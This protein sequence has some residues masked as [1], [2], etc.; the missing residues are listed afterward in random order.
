MRATDFEFR[1][2][3]WISTAIYL[4]GLSIYIFD[5]VNIVQ[6]LIDRTVGR[7]APNADLLA[8][9]IFGAGAFLLFLF[10]TSGATISFLRLTGIEEAKLER[11]QGNRYREFCRRVPRF[12]PSLKPRSP[13]GGIKPQWKQSF[14]G[15]IHMWGFL[16]A[17]RR[18]PLP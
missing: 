11:E 3:F 7:G 17:W 14:L 16:W 6:Y 2:R 18:S 9:V 10:L 13:A 12:W 15:E 5:H 8:H 1:R 4:L